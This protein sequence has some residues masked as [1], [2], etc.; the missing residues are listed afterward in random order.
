M[1]YHYTR[2]YIHFR[3]M[4][5][6]IE[7]LAIVPALIGLTVYGTFGIVVMVWLLYR[8][9]PKHVAKTRSPLFPE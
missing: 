4:D 3:R 8:P 9:E 7:A 2:C 5:M 6:F 1:G